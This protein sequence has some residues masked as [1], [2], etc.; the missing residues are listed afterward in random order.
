[1][2]GPKELTM[3]TLAE[4]PLLRAWMRTPAA[5]DAGSHVDSMYMWLFWFCVAWFV[6]LMGLAGWWVVKYRRRPGRIADFSASHTTPLE[7]AWTIIPTLFLVYIFFR[8]FDGYL[9]SV[10]SPGDAIELN[11][12]GKKWA[13]ELE[14]PKGAMATETTIVGAQQVPVFYIPAE[15]AVRLKMLSDDVMHAFWVPDFRVKQDVHPNRYTAL[16]FKAHAPSGDLRL[17]V[18]EPGTLDEKNPVKRALSGV[19]YSDHWV[20]CAEY[21]GDNHSEM[22]A[23]IRVIPQ[24]AFDRWLDAA[25]VGSMAPE[26]LGR[27]LWK[28]QCSSC[29]SIDGSKNTGPTWLNLYG[30]EEVMTDGSTVTACD[31]YI[32][33]SIINPQ[34]KIVKGYENANMSSFAHYTNDQ[35]NG[36][37]AF[38][39]TISDKGGEDSPCNTVNEQK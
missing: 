14:Y 35:I 31:N 17:P 21:C 19:A 4:D 20:F 39:R 30:R 9:K 6:L 27:L 8:G 11:L 1:M 3:L 12:R 26:D 37:I 15:K 18:V 16:W 32:R 24:D 36:I 7:I 13:W 10:V 2:M 29:H 33:E 23:I 25:G 5:T 28:T 22:A 34:A 38:M